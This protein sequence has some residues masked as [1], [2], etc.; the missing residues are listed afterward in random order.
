MNEFFSKIEDFLFDILGLVLPGVIILFIL[1]LPSYF[2][3]I[4]HLPA[5]ATDESLIL[6]WLTTLSDI[7]K[8]LWSQNINTIILIFLIVGYLMGHVV[9]VFSIIQYE[10]SRVIFDK[11]INKLANYLFEFIK[12]ILYRFI[13]W[14]SN[15]NM[16]SG[17]L[18]IYL[19]ILFSPIR[20]LLNKIFTFEPP[21]YFSDNNSLR[22]ECI[23]IIN[24]RL[25]TNYPN[26]WYSLFKFSKI[27]NSQENIKSLAGTFLAKYNLYRSLAFIFIFAFFYINYVFITCYNYL[28]PELSRITFIVLLIVLLLWFTFHYKFKRYWTLCGN[29]I[30]ISLYYY[31]NKKKLNET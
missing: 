13:K 16:Y 29:E 18:Y 30:L 8:K 21:E 23:Q 28:F 15:K 26:K 11:S 1:A 12:S 14:I 7:L 4:S 22:T 6:S 10:L 24:K 20:S 25:N 3:D 2:I 27:L 31:L 5:K 9:K 17:H 19:K